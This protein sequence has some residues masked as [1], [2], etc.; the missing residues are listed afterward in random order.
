MTDGEIETVIRDLESRAKTWS[1]DHYCD[2]HDP[3]YGG[4]GEPIPRF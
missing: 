2:G 3:V 1:V 4:D